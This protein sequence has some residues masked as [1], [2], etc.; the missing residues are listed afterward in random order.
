MPTPRRSVA[1]AALA[2]AAAVAAAAIGQALAETHRRYVGTPFH[3]GKLNSEILSDPA[4][5]NLSAMVLEEIVDDPAGGVCVRLRRDFTRAEL[6]AV[7]AVV[8]AHDPTP[9]SGNLTD[10]N[11]PEAA[12][13]WRLTDAGKLH[14]Y[15]PGLGWRKVATAA[16]DLSDD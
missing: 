1:F 2:L 9:P 10:T 5:S 7:D 4:C 3:P 12:F 6:A 13:V 15:L 14:V 11:Q 16:A 8:A